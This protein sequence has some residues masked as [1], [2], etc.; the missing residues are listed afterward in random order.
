ML[1]ML[2]QLHDSFTYTVKKVVNIIR[3]W[4]F[5]VKEHCFSAFLNKINTIKIFLDK[6]LNHDCN[7]PKRDTWKK[8]NTPIKT[9]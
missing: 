2:T 6:W 7:K 3:E 1:L 5:S 9:H 4:H 8:L